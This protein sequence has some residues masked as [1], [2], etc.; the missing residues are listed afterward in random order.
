MSQNPQATPP[1]PDELT[2]VLRQLLNRTA[3]INALLASVGIGVTLYVYLR[4]PIPSEIIHHGID[5]FGEPLQPE[6][7]VSYLFSIP[8]FLIWLVVMPLWGS[9]RAISMTSD[10]AAVKAREKLPWVRWAKP[11]EPSAPFFQ[12]LCICLVGVQILVLSATIF[13]AVS[14]ALGS[15]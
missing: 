14:A 15:F 1:A 3:I 2:G 4:F 9:K 12:L 6:S 8:C 7:A 11:M 5:K 10:A 13:R